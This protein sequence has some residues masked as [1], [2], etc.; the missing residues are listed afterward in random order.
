MP[1]LKVPL[2]IKLLAIANLELFVKPKSCKFLPFYA[3]LLKDESIP[4]FLDM[5]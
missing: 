5:P 4:S 2:K 3:R 1:M